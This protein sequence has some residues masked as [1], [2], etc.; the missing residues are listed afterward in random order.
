MRATS[1]FVRLFIRGLA[2]DAED[3]SATFADTLKAAARAKLTGSS[4]GK[5]LTGTMSGGTSVTF[6]LP[7][8]GTL[9]ADDVAEV[10]ALILDRVDALLVE[11]PGLTDAELLA[12]LLLQFPSI[13]SS[14]LDH[15]T[16]L[17]RA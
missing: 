17:C 11:T 12:A 4:K 6:S 10:C 15:S 2:W 8:L 1:A 3:A 9:T 5:V 7:P 14:R 13:R 16:G